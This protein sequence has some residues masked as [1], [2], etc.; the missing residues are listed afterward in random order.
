MKKL[1]ITIILL[2]VAL[3]ISFGQDKVD[4]PRLFNKNSVP[5]YDNRPNSFLLG[6][7]WGCQ[8]KS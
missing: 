3:E 1:I 6:W 8:D 4:P 2:M 7:N 5:V